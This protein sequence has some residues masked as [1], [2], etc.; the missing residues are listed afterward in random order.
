MTT[1]TTTTNKTT[2]TLSDRPPVTVNK[3]AW[4]VIAS[5]SSFNG[6]HKCQAN[7]VW[8]IRVRQHEDGRTLVYGAEET[9]NGGMPIGYRETY[10]GFLLAA[11][12]DIVRA[13]RRV[14]GA[15]G[16]EEMAGAVIADLPAEDLT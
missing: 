5:D 16:H 3:D 15:I 2:I 8:W 14:A 13:I 6:Q 11:G 10:A 12:E 1:T 4:P 9:G 7:R